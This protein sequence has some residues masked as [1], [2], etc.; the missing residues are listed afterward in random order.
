M[1][2]ENTASDHQPN[3]LP[4]KAGTL[5]TDPTVG[6]RLSGPGAIDGMKLIATVGG[7][8]ACRK[9]HPQP[10]KHPQTKQVPR[11]SGRTGGKGPVS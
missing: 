2:A 11:A 9:Q 10:F 8:K 3:P 1:A 5:K 4:C 6:T 7:S